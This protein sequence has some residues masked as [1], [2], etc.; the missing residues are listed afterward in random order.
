MRDVNVIDLN[1]QKM[2]TN[3]DRIRRAILQPIPSVLIDDVGL[4]QT[5]SSSEEVY[6][7]VKRFVNYSGDYSLFAIKK[8]DF[9]RFEQLLGASNKRVSE[10]GRERFIKGLEEGLDKS[11]KYIRNIKEKSFFQ[12]L[13][14]LFTN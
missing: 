8:D 9:E 4:E 11:E 13:K 12:K 5:K 3:T 14:W 1:I 7:E 2:K 10:F 6:Y